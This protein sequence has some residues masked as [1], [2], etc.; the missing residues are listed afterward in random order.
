MIQELLIKNFAIIE[1]SHIVFEKGMTVLTGETGAGKCHY[2]KE[3]YGQSNLPVCSGYA[4]YRRIEY[5]IFDQDR[6]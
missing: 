6:R 4:E 3:Y 1:E 2:T 5:R